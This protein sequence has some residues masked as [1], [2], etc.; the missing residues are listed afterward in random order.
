M[1]DQS[2]EPVVEPYGEEP[3]FTTWKIRKGSFKPGEV[4]PPPIIVP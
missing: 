2:Q 3:E 4:G 1:V